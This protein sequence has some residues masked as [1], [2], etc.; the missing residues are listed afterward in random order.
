[1]SIPRWVEEYK[2]YSI[3]EQRTKLKLGS[4]L[5]CGAYGA[6]FSTNDESKVIKITSDHNEL[7]LASKVMD[8]RR[9][10]T[11]KGI[12][13]SDYL[14]GLVFLF[15]IYDL[16]STYVQKFGKD[17]NVYAI[18]RESVIPIVKYSEHIPNY[19]NIYRILDKVH[20]A[21]ADFHSS[22]GSIYS[23]DDTD[24]YMKSIYELE[25]YCPY[26]ATTFMELVRN[27]I[28]MKDTHAGNVGVSIV[29]WGAD[30]RP[31]GELVVFDLGFTPTSG[32]YDVEIK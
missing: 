12:G 28:V 10:D 4:L 27:G 23:Y 19:K 26:L 13:P 9:A 20:D 8:I 21:A 25:Q 17:T 3:V 5:G 32:D 2:H 22:N 1:M 7:I 16:P 24:K 31:P 29:D 6:V 15:G 18:V 11:R 30:Y 14:S